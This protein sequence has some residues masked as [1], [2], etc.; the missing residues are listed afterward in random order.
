[1]V[2]LKW[3]HQK[4]WNISPCPSHE[5]LLSILCV[6]W[7][8]A[9]WHGIPSDRCSCEYNKTMIRGLW[10][11]L[12]FMGLLQ[13]YQIT[14][15]LPFLTITESGVAEFTAHHGIATSIDLPSFPVLRFLIYAWGRE[16]V[17]GSRYKKRKS[18]GADKRS[19]GSGKSSPIQRPQERG[20]MTG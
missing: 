4:D 20:Q 12:D 11:I 9:S 14:C 2:N 10:G 1:M 8:G 6:L 13:P 18:A 3:Y 5:L 16:R 19:C 17:G 7:E 15:H